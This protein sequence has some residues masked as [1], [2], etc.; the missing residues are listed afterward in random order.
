MVPVLTESWTV[1]PTCV[2]TQGVQTLSPLTVR[3]VDVAVS[4]SGA[5][6]DGASALWTLHEGQVSDGAVVHAELQVW[7]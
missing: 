3:G 1:A 7:A 5:D 4:S 2:S 6:Q